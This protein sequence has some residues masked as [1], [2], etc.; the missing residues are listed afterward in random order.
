MTKLFLKL[1][2]VIGISLTIMNINHANAQMHCR[3]ILGSHLTPF[4]ENI[5]LLWALE[6]T[7]APGIMIPIGTE[8][9]AMLNGGMVIGALNYSFL[10]NHSLYLEGGYKNW[11]NSE[12]SQDI[13]GKQPLGMR[14]AFYQYSGNNVSATLG[15]QEMKLANYYLID[16]RIIGG[17]FD[18]ELNAWTF[19]LMTGTVTNAFARMGK[20]CGNKHL[21][22]L[23][24]EHYTEN[25]GK[26]LGETNMVAFVLNWDPAYEKPTESDNEFGE[27]SSFD[28][29]ENKQTAGLSNIGI[30]YYNEFGKIMPDVKHYFGSIQDW[31][32]PWDFKGQTG[33]VG[34][35]MPSNNAMVYHA[36]LGRN[37]NWKKGAMT[38]IE[39][40]YIGLL[41]VDKGAVFQPLFS[42]LFLGEIMRLDAADFPLWTAEIKHRF[43]GKAALHTAV[44]AVGQTS[45]NNTNEIDLE[46]GAKLFNHSK[47][48][49]I[50][51]HVQ[52]DA[53]ADDVFMTRLE[54]R[55]AF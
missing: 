46:I 43:P 2:V 6:G 7:M 19:N 38:E 33:L 5:P 44:K 28:D 37:I 49:A 30:L 34:Q 14:Q 11:K 31:D 27:F 48:T 32:L 55:V 8:D 12:L 54:V 50:L 20:F 47:I 17:N 42:N 23:I 29:G 22:N 35:A 18:Y 26:K 13:G 45:G 53:L 16:E 24:G 39:A 36:R 4:H 21:Y 9:K 10:D 51:S 1:A 25:I 41:E 52:T 40:G 15:L 3:S